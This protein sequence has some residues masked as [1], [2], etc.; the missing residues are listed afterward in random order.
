MCPRDPAAPKLGEYRGPGTFS[1][2]LVRQN[3][4][5]VPNPADGD[6]RERA[7]ENVFVLKTVPEADGNSLTT[8]RELETLYWSNFGSMRGFRARATSAYF[9]EAAF[10]REVVKVPWPRRLPS[11]SW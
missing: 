1:R 7:L 2:S 6:R 10:Q 5:A 3:R 8:R 9:G 4:T 11:L